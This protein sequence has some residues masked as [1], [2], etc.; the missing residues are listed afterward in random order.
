MYSPMKCGVELTSASAVTF[1][2]PH[3][4]QGMPKAAVGCPA[5]GSH[6]RF[7]ATHHVEAVLAVVAN[8]PEPLSS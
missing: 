7:K 8:L 5:L 4:C 3:S 6:G 1:S 2:N